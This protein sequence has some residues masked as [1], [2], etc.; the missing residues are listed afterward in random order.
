M[1]KAII[2]VPLLALGI[3]T[4]SLVYWNTF[5]FSVIERAVQPSPSV[6]D[7]LRIVDDRLEDKNP[8]FNPQLV[9]PQEH[10]GWQ[11]NKSSAVIRLDCPD[12][13]PDIESEKTILYASYQDAIEA[14]E[15][16]RE[17][18]IPSA[19]ML[20]GIAKQFDDGLYAALDLACFEGTAGLSPSAVDFIERLFT[21][22]P[23]KNEARP[24]L[25]AA[26]TLADK[27]VELTDSD[28][29]VCERWIKEFS[30]NQSR[31]QPISF[32]TWNEKLRRVWRFSRFLQHPF[33]A[34]DLAIPISLA[35]VLDSDPALNATYQELLSFYSGLTNPSVG[36]NL[37]DLKGDS[38]DLTSLRKQIQRQQLVVS[39]LPASTSRENELFDRM[40]ATRPAA[41]TNLMIA[42]LKQIRSG[43]VDLAPRDDSG[44]YDLQVYAL[45]T[46]VLPER[47]DEYQK[48][49]LTAKYKRRL[50]QAFQALITKRR[51][52]H[53]RQM[54]P[55][56]DSAVLA[57]GEIYPR[58]RIEPNATFYLRTARSYA[59]LEAFLLDH[60]EAGTLKKLH[61]L[62]KDGARK[63]GLKDE[64]SQIKQLFYGFYLISCEDIGIVPNLTESEATDLVDAYQQAETWLTDLDHYDLAAD[65]RV[66]VPI[67]NVVS[68]N[69]TRLWATIGVRLVKLN[70]RFERGPK[71]RKNEEAEWEEVKPYYL[72]D[73]DYVIP[74][75]EF[76]ELRVPAGQVLT[77][78]QLREFCDRYKTKTAIAEAISHK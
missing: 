7:G 12:I 75:D 64:L 17:R 45:E 53:A 61:G 11:L 30:A 78:K 77:R 73:A 76:S 33:T 16:Q 65:T 58:L 38:P 57:A 70:A 24:F 71:M 42:L 41:E 48:L 31:S 22:L 15:A 39:M 5:Y 26:L 40:F 32:Y 49:L 63:L 13:Q 62:R 36:F 19:N 28:Q 18:L 4:A 54:M 43:N 72:S 20:D 69:S 47:G 52:T 1:K 29:L 27:P 66:S 50:L 68:D 25:A 2:W 59:F 44:W 8:A 46:L 21:A 74:V 9:D 14:A 6:Q 51:E 34:D 35:T 10:G 67:M 60:L 37:S 55:S 3:A 56:S 23:A